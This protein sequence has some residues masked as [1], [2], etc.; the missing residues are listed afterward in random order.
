MKVKIA[1][2]YFVEE[3]RSLFVR[4]HVAGKQTMKRT[5][6]ERAVSLIE[7]SLDRDLKEGFRKREHGYDV[8]SITES[9]QQA[10][11]GLIPA[12]QAEQE[13]EYLREVVEV[14]RETLSKAELRLAEVDSSRGSVAFL[15]RQRE[16]A[17]ARQ[18]AQERKAG[19]Q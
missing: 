5:E 6:S 9:K 8:A 18:R 3:I 7:N 12:E 19:V 17:A 2:R 15:S 14:L 10:I 16:L 4:I 13:A 11:A 1:G